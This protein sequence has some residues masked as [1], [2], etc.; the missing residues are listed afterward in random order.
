M[1]TE[2]YVGMDVHQASTTVVVLDDRGKCVMESIIE[3]K[4]GTIRDLLKG[5][6][7]GVHVALEE[8]TQAA[9]LYEIV[10]PLVA[11][12]IVCNPR[13]NKGLM[14]GNKDDRI[15]AHK[16]AHLLRAGLL[17]AVYHGGHSTRELKELVH[18]YESVVS[19]S[20]RVMS[21]LKALFRGRGIGSAGR[22]IY[23]VKSSEKWLAKIS[24]PGAK[25]RA[26][27]L[28]DELKALKEIRR[29]SKKL[30]L[31]GSGRHQA[32]KLL[33][34]IPGIGP[35][36]AA[37]IVGTVSTPHRFRT[38]RQFWTY[39][40]FAV[41]TRS[42]S[43]YRFEGSKLVRDRKRV[44]TRGLNRNYNRRLKAVFKGAVEQAIKQEPFKS[45]WEHLKKRNVSPAIA[46]V[47]VARKLA[48]VTLAVWKNSE[49]FDVGKCK[50]SP[51][52]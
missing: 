20:V 21:R 3:T 25:S 39:C 48:A 5:V 52:L 32:T 15:D 37:V 43:D 33:S 18:N 6:S 40:G 12:V 17:K 24:E 42:S 41:V 38:R 8:G 50:P 29:D 46:R 44:T 2:K 7:G 47:S 30:L 27:I 23:D 31:S 51:E 13:A 28:Y 34:S 36:R 49:K 9:W 26:G 10:R 14:E 11:E 45:Y 19:D 1:N 22:A 16:I 4:A 35:V